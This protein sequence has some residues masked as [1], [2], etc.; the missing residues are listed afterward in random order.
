MQLCSL[1]MPATDANIKLALGDSGLWVIDPL[2]GDVYGVIIAGSHYLGEIYVIP[3]A[4]ISKDIGSKLR[5]VNV[6][7]PT[8][9]DTLL[10][11][12]RHGNDSLVQRLLEGHVE[13]SHMH[14][15]WAALQAGAKGGHYKVVMMLLDAGVDVND[16]GGYGRRTALQ[17]AAG[18]GH[19]EVVK[20]L[21]EAGADVNVAAAEYE[22]RTALQAAAG[23]GHLEMVK[24]L[25]DAG[26]DVNAATRYGGQTALQAAAGGGYLEV[27]EL[28]VDA[29]ADN[30]AAAE[31]DDTAASRSRMSL[32]KWSPPHRMSVLDTE[33]ERVA[34]TKIQMQKMA[35]DKSEFIDIETAMANPVF[36]GVAEQYSPSEKIRRRAEI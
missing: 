9:E 23:N 30:A 11:A 19:L 18:G 16:A 8:M 29:G 36:H 35:Q 6:A 14:S 7:L 3:T 34:V 27:V 28:L 25:V 31:Y 1:R 17:A 20:V 10:L 12:S 5:A 33:A 15:G 21:V 24:M 13:I 22:G 2:S 4:E 32:G 26:A